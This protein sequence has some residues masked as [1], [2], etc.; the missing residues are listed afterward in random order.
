[1]RASQYLALLVVS[2]LPVL[3]ACCPCGESAAVAP[4][5]PQAAAIALTD[6][7]GRACT[8]LDSADGRAATVILFL[9]H[10]CPVANASAPAIARLA[11]DFG[12]RGV[13]FFGVYATET[14]EEINTHRRD[15]SLPFPGLTDAKLQLA[16]HAGATRVPEAAVF[17]P[18]GDLLY[19][20][21]IDDRAVSPGVTRPEPR[22][23]DLRLALEAV[24][25][26]NKPE[27]QFT[28]AIGC[29]L[30]LD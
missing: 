2:V 26:G 28:E 16:R 19:R 24:L 6:S 25:A 29:Y 23:H 10:D 13:K 17:S 21:R 7:E 14:A 15:F 3:S 9:M 22:R 11:G 5:K 12:A 27:P 20:G 18:S 4:A 1:M 30:P 8:P